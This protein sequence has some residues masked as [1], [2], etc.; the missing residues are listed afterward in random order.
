MI[1]RKHEP[2]ISAHTTLRPVL[3]LFHL[4]SLIGAES[5]SNGSTIRSKF[6]TDDGIL[7]W[8]AIWSSIID[9]RY[10]KFLMIN[11]SR[12]REYDKALE[13]FWWWTG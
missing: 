6:P 1:K 11:V 12:F 2:S 13:C 3:R 4:A 8:V 9:G 5:S 10:S 7:V